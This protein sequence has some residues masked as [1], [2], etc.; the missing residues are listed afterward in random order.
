[1][2]ELSLCEEV[3]RIVTEEAER[4]GLS[5]IK[6]VHLRIGALSCVEIE[7]LRFSFDPVMAGSVAEGAALRVEHVAGRARC[8][9]CGLEFE[10][11]SRWELCPHCDAVTGD[12][13][14]GDEMHVARIEADGPA[15][16]AGVN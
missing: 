7:A 14:C 15:P 2:H 16:T 3:R 6:A 5:R 12:I 4:H 11:A 8:A 13:V 10:V 9:N 1:M